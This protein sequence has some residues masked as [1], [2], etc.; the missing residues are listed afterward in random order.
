MPIYEYRCPDCG[1]EFDKIQKMSD[2]APE[3]PDCGHEEVVKKVSRTSFQLKGTGW[4][5]TDYKDKPTAATSKAAD[6]SAGSTTDGGGATESAG[7]SESAASA[8][9]PG[10]GDSPAPSSPPSTTT[11]SDAA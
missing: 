1:H 4:Y 10:G 5:V 3:C 6:A 8:S 11:G 9:D 7:A 2:P